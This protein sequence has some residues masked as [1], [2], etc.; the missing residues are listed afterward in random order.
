MF[1]ESKSIFRAVN[2]NQ[3]GALYLS[4]TAD[5][6]IFYPVIFKMIV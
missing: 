1:C 4:K 2:H 6:W 3:A 5:T